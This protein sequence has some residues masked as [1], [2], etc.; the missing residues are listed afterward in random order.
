VRT[1]GVGTPQRTRLAP[2]V[3]LIAET[4]PAYELLGGHWLLAPLNTR[5]DIIVKVN[6]IVTQAVLSAE[7]Q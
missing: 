3:P 6:A 5:S 1:L 7:M 4:L 2:Y